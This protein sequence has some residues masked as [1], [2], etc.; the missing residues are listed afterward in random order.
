MEYLKIKV[1][2]RIKYGRED[3]EVLAFIR[4]WNGRSFVID[5]YSVTRLAVSAIH[6]S[7]SRLEERGLIK[8]TILNKSG[9]KHVE[10]IE[11]EVKKDTIND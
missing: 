5:C 11:Q 2:D 9:K 7:L 10:L 1:E 3:S 4:E 8:I 6:K